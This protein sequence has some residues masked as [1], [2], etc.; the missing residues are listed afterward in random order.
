M[1]A[2]AVA[3]YLQ[4]VLRTPSPE[5]AN[6]QRA[7]LTE[8]LGVAPVLDYTVTVAREHATLLAH[9]RRDRQPR[10]AH[11]LIIAATARASDRIVLTTDRRARFDE[12]PDVEVRIVSS[13]EDPA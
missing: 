10:G 3:E 12:L 4:G 6:A 1:P 5:R 8:V 7:F 2:L 11:D 13:P 9:V